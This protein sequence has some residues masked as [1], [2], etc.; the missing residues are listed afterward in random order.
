[1]PGHIPFLTVIL[2][3]PFAEPSLC[4]VVRSGLERLLPDAR[5]AGV[6]FVLVSSDAGQLSE[7]FRSSPNPFAIIA[8][9]LRSKAES[10]EILNRSGVEAI[11]ER[12]MYYF[13]D[14]SAGEVSDSS[15]Y[16]YVMANEAMPDV[17]KIG[18]TA[19]S[20]SK[21]A[22]E[23]SGTSVPTSFRVIHE[24]LVSDQ[25]AAERMVHRALGQFRKN[26]SR[27]FFSVTPE[28]AIEAVS[29]AEQEFPA[30]AANGSRMRRCIAPVE[31]ADDR[32]LKEIVNFLKRNGPPQFARFSPQDVATNQ[33]NLI[34]EDLYWRAIDVLRS[35]RRATISMLQR[36]LGIGYNRAGE[37]LEL[38]EVRGVVG[39][40]NGPNPREILDLGD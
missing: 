8:H 40:E 14:P 17:V 34:D 10:V 31:G 39:P 32:L 19:D 23:L 1:M 2:D 27:E 5:A 15:G 12:G 33:D 26:S 6:Q 25:V 24:V 36:R 20:P 16:V 11:S 21:R 38:M 28:Q 9:R 3:E 18:R 37:L 35:T 30:I 22:R 4:S 29:R 13:F 7:I